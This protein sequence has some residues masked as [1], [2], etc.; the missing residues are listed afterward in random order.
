[1]TCSI[2]TSSIT[3]LHLIRSSAKF[4][5]PS[6]KKSRR[7]CWAGELSRYSQTF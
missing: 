5:Q 1:M 3:S 4:F 2:G 6:E 7:I